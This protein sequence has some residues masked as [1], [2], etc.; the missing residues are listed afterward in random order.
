M[1]LILLT[2]L[3]FFIVTPVSAQENP[4]NLSDAEIEES[5][6]PV[7]KDVEG[8]RIKLIE[9]PQDPETKNVRFTVVVYS[10][11]RSD[12]VQL[13][14]SLNGGTD[15]ITPYDQVSFRVDPGTV[16]TTQT[17]VKPRTRG[18]SILSVEVEAFEIEGSYL[19]TGFKRIY[20]LGDGRRLPI[21]S[22][23]NQL[24]IV[25]GVKGT[26]TTFLQIALFLLIIRAGYGIFQKWLNRTEEIEGII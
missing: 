9:H 21:T 6:E 11:I 10:Q 25:V 20:S 19:S 3:A 17:V 24:E 23:Y 26:A 14:W 13:R 22:T 1:R 12:R 18:V 16:K 4:N 7:I 2:I 8:L 15:L 5:I